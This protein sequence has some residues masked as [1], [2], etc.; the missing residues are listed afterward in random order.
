MKTKRILA[1]VIDCL[2]ST[3][4]GLGV[5]EALSNS[6][7]VPIVLFCAYYILLEYFWGKTLGKFIMG[8]KVVNNDN[9]KISIR[10]ACL[11][12]L[13]RFKHIFHLRTMFYHD[14]FSGTKIV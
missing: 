2:F 10:T 11:R 9:S 7:L 8:I 5:P 13:G 14:S 1:F 6:F 12:H 4:I 3:V